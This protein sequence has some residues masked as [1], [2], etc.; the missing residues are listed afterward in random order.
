MTVNIKD[1]EESDAD[2][3]AELMVQLS[4]ETTHTLMTEQESIELGKS[5]RERTRQLVLAANQKILLAGQDGLL[6]G[7]LGLSQGLFERN[8]HSAALMTG[9]LAEYW[10]QGIASQLMEQVLA[11]ADARGIQRIEVGVMG[12]NERAIELYQRFGF[13]QEGV[14]QRALL[15]NGVYQNEKLMARLKR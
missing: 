7:F 2:A 15:I 10:G 4:R 13:E 6:T 1:L 8:R 9:V 14:R 11:W 3:F 12:S 5:Q